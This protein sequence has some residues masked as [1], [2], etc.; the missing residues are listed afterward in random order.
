MVDYVVHR[1]SHISDF[2]VSEQWAGIIEE[3]VAPWW[4]LLVCI[5]VENVNNILWRDSLG[6]FFSG[7]EMQIL[8]CV[9]KI[10]SFLIVVPGKCIL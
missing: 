6:S 1:V 3:L 4:F 7:M 2:S 5:T 8:G 9:Q 10:C